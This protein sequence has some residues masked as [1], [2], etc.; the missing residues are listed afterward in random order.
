MA[1]AGFSTGSRSYLLHAVVPEHSNNE[2]QEDIVNEAV[3]VK[4]G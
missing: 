3:K 4:N 1:Q 2:H